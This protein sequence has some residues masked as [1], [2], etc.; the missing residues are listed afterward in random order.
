MVYENTCM[1]PR[2][3]QHKSSPT[4]SNDQAYP[5]SPR[6]H[7]SQPARSDLSGDVRPEHQSRDGCQSAGNRSDANIKPHPLK[8][9]N[10]PSSSEDSAST[11]R[12]NSI[13]NLR[14]LRPEVSNPGL[15]LEIP[16]CGNP[17]SIAFGEHTPTPKSIPT[18]RRPVVDAMPKPMR[19]KQPFPETTAM[20]D[21]L[22][23]PS[24]K[25]IRLRKS[26]PTTH[27][28]AYDATPTAIT[29][30]RTSAPSNTMGDPEDLSPVKFGKR[31]LNSNA[32]PTARRSGDDATPTP[33][34]KAQPLANVDA[35][36]ELALEP[37]TVASQ[38]NSNPSSV[39]SASQLASSS[40]F[41][42]TGIPASQDEETDASYRKAIRRSLVE[43]LYQEVRGW[44]WVKLNDEESKRFLRFDN[45]LNSS[46]LP[47]ADQFDLIWRRNE[48]HALSGQMRHDRRS[49]III[50]STPKLFSLDRLRCWMYFNMHRCKHDHPSLLETNSDTRKY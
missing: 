44:R 26:F 48:A 47:S 13:P 32:I 23:N 2:S 4:F 49:S 14:A 7:P 41:W 20:E 29:K 3:L 38:R 24:S 1:Y 37:V 28:P 9:R 8:H 19:K 18:T 35:E 45:D 36:G 15:G 34:A 22:S 17:F 5:S 46:K 31:M 33:L 10:R 12:G 11:V 39:R 43:R 27:R 42:R 21:P 30:K 6:S 16:N 25:Q 50:F 40:G